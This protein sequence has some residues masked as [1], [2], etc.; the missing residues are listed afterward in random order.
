MDVDDSSSQPVSVTDGRPRRRLYSAPRRFDLATVFVVTTAYAL[1]FSGLSAIGSSPT[2]S[3]MVG[4]FITIV[5]LGQ[6]LLFGGK[7]PR[8][9]SM[10][11]GVAIFAL[12]MLWSIGYF[13][14]A[15]SPVY[16]IAFIVALHLVATIVEGALFG[17]FAGVLVG[18]V[19]LLA[20]VLRRRF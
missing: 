1:L 6:A 16:E 9:A 19:F 15:Q 11:M 3:A 8:L 10:T 12:I 13:S 2:S 4:G 7:S 18:G 20:D 14:V 17:Y 5:G